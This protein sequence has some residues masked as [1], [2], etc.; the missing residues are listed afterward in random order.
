MLSSIIFKSPNLH[1]AGDFWYFNTH[2]LIIDSVERNNLTAFQEW[3]SVKTWRLAGSFLKSPIANTCQNQTAHLPTGEDLCAS[4]PGMKPKIRVS[5]RSLYHPLYMSGMMPNTGSHQKKRSNW[6]TRSVSTA[7]RIADL[8]GLSAMVTTAAVWTD[9][10]VM[11]AF[12]TS[13]LLRA[14]S[15]T[16]GRSPYPNG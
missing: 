5:P 14:R 12:I 1:Q 10:T 15:S 11:T 7:A 4:F 9:I 8:S 6:S 16:I 2:S 3:I 13:A